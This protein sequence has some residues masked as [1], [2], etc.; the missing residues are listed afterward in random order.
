[1]SSLLKEGHRPAAD[2]LISKIIDAESENRTSWARYISFI[3]EGE[4]TLDGSFELKELRAV[5]DLMA[6]WSDDF[7]EQ[8]RRVI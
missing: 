4:V 2:E 3:D 6:D 8:V 1:M 7:R 5:V